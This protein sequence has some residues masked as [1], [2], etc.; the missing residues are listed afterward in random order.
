MST[1]MVAAV[2]VSE[3]VA[4]RPDPYA[5]AFDSTR[6]VPTVSRDL[7]RNSAQVTR[8]FLGD[9]VRAR[10]RSGSDLPQPGDGTILRRDGTD[11]AVARTHDG[12]LVAVRAACTHLG[13]LVAH[14][15]ADQSWDCPCH[16]S[17]FGLDGTVLE[18][19]ASAP[20]ERVD[21]HDTERAG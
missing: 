20:L 9:R 17:R 3:L 12:Q 8:R 14:N 5:G 13:C 2:V 15:A 21:L 18:G 19:P 1:S 16:G 11:V 10:V 4:G 7:V 6:I